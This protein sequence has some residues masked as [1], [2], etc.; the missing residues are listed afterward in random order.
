MTSTDPLLNSTLQH[1]RELRQTLLR[2]HKAL[3]DS[4]RVE[5]EQ[6]HGRIKSSNEF[7]QLVIGD[8]WFSWLRPI[9]QFIIQIDEFLGSK[10]PVTL[11]EANQ[12]LEQARVLIQ[13][14]AEGTLLEKQYFRAIQRD[15]DIAFMNAEVTKMLAK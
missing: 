9:S 15:P 8:E 13:P 5:Y 3:L 2:L 4:E 1:L 14:C 7:F 6:F 10:E 12:L 11:N